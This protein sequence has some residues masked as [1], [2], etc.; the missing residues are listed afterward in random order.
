VIQ[1]RGPAGLSDEELTEFGQLYRRATS[2]LSSARTL[3]LDAATVAYLNGLVGR[4]YGYLY[5]TPSRGWRSVIEFFAR[6]FPRAIRRHAWVILLAT[7]A[8]LVPAAFAAVQVRHEMTTVNTLV[9]G[10]MA[11]VDQQVERHAKPGTDWMKAEQRPAIS[12]FIMQNNLRVAVLAFAS[13]MLLALPSLLILAQNGLMLGGIAA[14]VQA[15]GAALSFWAFV[16]PHGVLEL[17]AIF[18]SGA[19]GMLIG[20]AMID[21]GEH[22]RAVAVRLAAHE[23]VRLVMGVIAMLVIAGVIEGFFSPAVMP[24]PIKF[25]V[26]AIE[27]VVM[28]AYFIL[29]GRDPAPASSAANRPP[30]G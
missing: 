2:D 4:A 28:L 1:S 10:G 17:T 21:P 16:A 7:L 12:A 15:R 22:R 6:D 18:I 14:A 23:A 5:V 19:A 26:A 3:G 13:G 30:A 24:W 27:L 29:A 25:A 20:Y 8:S 11:T 9:P